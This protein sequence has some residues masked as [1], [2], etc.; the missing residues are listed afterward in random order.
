VLITGSAAI[1]AERSEKR[2]TR[3]PAALSRLL[4]RIRKDGAP[5]NRAG[6][7]LHAVLVELFIFLVPSG[8]IIFLRPEDVGHASSF[9]IIMGGMIGCGMEGSKPG[10]IRDQ[11]SDVRCQ[12]S[13]RDG[14]EIRGQASGIRGQGD[15]RR[16]IR[17]EI[18][19]QASGIRGQW[20]GREIRGQGSGVSGRRG[21]EE[22]SGT[23]RPTLEGM[24]RQE[25]PT[26]REREST[27]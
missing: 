11:L 18:R 5:A 16:E 6:F 25:C 1:A 2:R 3:D 8:L 9:S 12:L 15:G 14:G 10:R 21:R 4:T 22:G 7:E 24:V 23:G 27:Q 20:D 13:V 19:G 17:G 26:Y